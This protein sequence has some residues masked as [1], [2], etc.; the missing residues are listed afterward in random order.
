MENYIDDLYE[1]SDKIFVFETSDCERILRQRAGNA[2]RKTTIYDPATRQRGTVYYYNG[3]DATII[4][5]YNRRL[6]YISDMNIL[7]NYRRTFKPCVQ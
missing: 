4:C 2:M 3:H 1:F 5:S 7:S 6:M